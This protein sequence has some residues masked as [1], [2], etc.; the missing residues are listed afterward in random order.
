MSRCFDGF[1]GRLICRAWRSG[2]Y[3][4]QLRND[5]ALRY[6]YAPFSPFS[7]LPDLAD[8]HC[9]KAKVSNFLKLKIEQ[10]RHINTTLLSST[11]FAN[12]HIYS[13]LVS[14]P[15]VVAAEHG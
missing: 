14:H 1:R 8:G 13:K 12:P 11:A 7:V 15:S 4:H 10:D 5:R 2:E 3:R 6:R 9:T